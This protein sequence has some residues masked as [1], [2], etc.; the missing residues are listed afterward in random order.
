MR[1]F[2]RFAFFVDSIDSSMCRSDRFVDSSPRS[3]RSIPRFVHSSIQSIHPLVRFVDASS[4]PFDRFVGSSIP[5]FHQFCRF[6][7]CRHYELH[8]WVPSHLDITLRRMFFFRTMTL[9]NV[10]KNSFGQYRDNLRIQQWHQKCFQAMTLEILF[11]IITSKNRNQ[12]N[13]PRVNFSA[14]DFNV[15]VRHICSRYR[16]NK[17]FDVLV[18]NCFST[19]LSEDIFDVIVG[20]GNFHVILQ[21]NFFTSLPKKHFNLLNVI[22]QMKGYSVVQFIVT[23]ST[24]LN[25]WNRRTDQIDES[26]SRRIDWMDVSTHR[27]IDPVDESTESTNRSNRT[28]RTWAS[29]VK[30]PGKIQRLFESIYPHLSCNAISISRSLSLSV[31]IRI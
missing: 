22:V 2:G 8:C 7:R 19:L 14:C 20:K 16:P 21:K 17:C 25:W 18:Q 23:A 15:I 11:W 6:R 26:T 31:S 30:T 28:K 3:I 13:W 24:K 29:V 1:R 12:K 27:R 9:N 5:R 10:K 4:R